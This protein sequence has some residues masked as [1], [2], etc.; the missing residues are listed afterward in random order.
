MEY[1]LTLSTRVFQTTIEAL[2]VLKDRP[3]FQ[4]GRYNLPGGKIEL[5][6]SPWH[7]AKRELLEETGYEAKNVSLMG[8]IFSNNDIVYCFN[9]ELYHP[10]Y[11]IKSQAGETEIV[12]WIKLE[13]LLHSPKLMPNLF[14]IIPMMICECK[15]W[16]VHDTTDS[17]IGFPHKFSIEK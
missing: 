10:Y 4:R 6:E 3:E 13:E 5:N 12:S 1:V 14:A 15:E 7:T 2:V 16:I 11:P 8:R 9:A 17:K